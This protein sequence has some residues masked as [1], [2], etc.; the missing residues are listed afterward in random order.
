[1]KIQSVFLG[2]GCLLLLLIAFWDLSEAG[3]LI[4]D[5]RMPEMSGIEVQEKVVHSGS[6]MPA[7]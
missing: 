1:M 5:V 6:K 2:A 4:L 7:C 3:I